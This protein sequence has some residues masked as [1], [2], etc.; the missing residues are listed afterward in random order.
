MGTCICGA[1]FT[2]YEQLEDGVLYTCSECGATEFEPFD[3]E[4]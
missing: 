3:E 1:V 2:E 4:V